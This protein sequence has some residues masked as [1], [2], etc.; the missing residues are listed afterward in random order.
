MCLLAQ[1]RDLARILGVFVMVELRRVVLSGSEY[2]G[3]QVRLAPDNA[4][5][6]LRGRAADG[7]D[8][9]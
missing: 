6:R 5:D 1:V 9:K 4:V 2:L 8:G 7:A 3:E